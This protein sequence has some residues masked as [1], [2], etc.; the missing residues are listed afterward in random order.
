VPDNVLPLIA[1]VR[2]VLDEVHAVSDSFRLVALTYQQF[3]PLF[4]LSDDSLFAKDARR[5]R[6]MESPGT[7]C[8]VSLADAEVG[9]EVL[10]VPFVH[11]DVASPYRA[12]GPIFIRHRA[13]TAEPGRGEIPTMLHHRLLSIRAYDANAMMVGAEVLA[14]V[15]LGPAILRAFADPTIL[16]LH[17]HNAKPGCFN[18]R[19]E[20]A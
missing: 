9:E 14:G 10:L 19:V 18:C 4:T 7:P 15:Q 20:R 13:V 8:R 1:S 2:R 12:S 3:E 16:Y 6:V 11:H 17:V 5:V